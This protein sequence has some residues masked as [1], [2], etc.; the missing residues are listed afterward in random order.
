MQKIII[1]GN[2]GSGKSS[3]AKMY[4][5]KHGLSHLDLDTLAW[6]DT[7]PP[8][9]KPIVESEVVI[10]NF[11]KNNIKW[12]IE[13]CYSD[14]LSIAINQA[15]KVVF[16]NPGVTTCIENCRNRSWEPHK[17]I[18]MDEQNKNLEMLISWVKEYPARNDEFSFKSHTELYN[19]FS[20]KKE[21]YTANQKIT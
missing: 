11:L 9:C 17:Y 19:N 16:L 21:E 5:A 18:S 2:S 12:V 6:L 8:Q 1:F 20:G 7:K 3:L 4:S 15:S 13:G 14:L 10:E